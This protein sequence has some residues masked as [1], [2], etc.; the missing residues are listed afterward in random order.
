[1]PEI[2]ESVLVTIRRDKIPDENGPCANHVAR[3][4]EKSATL[5]P[6]LVVRKAKSMSKFRDIEILVHVHFFFMKS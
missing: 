1:M 6:G 3:D 5:N 2:W 4:D